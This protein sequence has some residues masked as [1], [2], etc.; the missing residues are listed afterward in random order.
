MCTHVHVW[1]FVWVWVWVWVHIVVVGRLQNFMLA[2]LCPAASHA[3]LPPF[4]C[5]CAYIAVTELN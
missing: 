4:M 1:T 3:L 2:P 5:G